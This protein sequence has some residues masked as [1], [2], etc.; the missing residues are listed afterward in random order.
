MGA[1]QQNQILPIPSFFDKALFDK[2]YMTRDA[3]IREEAMV[4]SRDNNITPATDD[5]QRIA[6]FGIDVQGGFCLPGASLFVNGA[7]EDSIRTAE[8]IL[9]NMNKITSLHFSLDTHHVYQIFHPTWWW[10]TTTNDHPAPLT[11]ITSELIKQNRFRPLR[12]P[13]DS[14]A[15][16]EEL[17]KT[18]KYAL[19]IWP[20]HTLLGS[21]GHAMVPA[22]FEAAMFYAVA[23][24]Q[25]INFETKGEHV[26]TENYSVMSPEVKKVRGKVV[27]QFNTK[28]FKALMENDRV[29]IVGQASSHC[30]KT[31]IEDLLREIQL[32]DPALADKVYILEDCTSPVAAVVDEKG[33][34]IVD[35]P[36]IAKQA[37]EDFKAAG[38][39]VVKSTDDIAA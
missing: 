14:L 8:F 28:F 6:L 2:L 1:N 29:Y 32:V 26:L 39:H 23:R 18:G 4:Y 37:F 13:L 22:V 24:R 19:I 21:P 33:N 17:E 5:D 34:T 11:I 10:D 12:L 7:V 35:F 36:A 3:Q 16:V 38:M 30:V 25:Q 31:T 9:R 15:Y 27:G 20:Y